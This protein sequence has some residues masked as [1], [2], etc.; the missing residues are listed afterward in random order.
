MGEPCAWFEFMG[1]GPG[2]V[3]SDP[4]AEHDGR[5]PEYYSE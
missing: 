3:I 5:E 4:D 1:T 2:C